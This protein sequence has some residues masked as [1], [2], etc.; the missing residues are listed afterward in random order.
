MDLNPFFNWV[1]GICLTIVLRAF[2]TSG[3]VYSVVAK[4]MLSTRW[5]GPQEEPLAQVRV[6]SGSEAGPRGHSSLENRKIA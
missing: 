3:I 4:A 2:R 1:V 6:G 5:L